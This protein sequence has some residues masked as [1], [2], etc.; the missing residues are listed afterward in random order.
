M[1]F[2]LKS[3]EKYNNMDLLSLYDFIIEL[4]AEKEFDNVLRLIHDT[5]F[6]HS[7]M[8]QLLEK[9]FVELNFSSW[10]HLSVQEKTFLRLQLF[11][12]PELL[13]TLSN[14]QN[15]FDFIISTSPFGNRDNLKITIDHD[16]LM[17]NTLFF[18]FLYQQHIHFFSLSIKNQTT[19]NKKM[20]DIIHQ[21]YIVYFESVKINQWTNLNPSYKNELGNIG[22]FH[23]LEQIHYPFFHKYVQQHI[24]AIH[25]INF[26]SIYPHIYMHN[27]YTVLFRGPKSDVECSLLYPERGEQEKHIKLFSFLKKLR[28][29]IQYN[30]N[31]VD[32]DLKIYIQDESLNILACHKIMDTY[33]A[34]ILNDQ[35]NNFFWERIDILISILN[36]LHNKDLTYDIFSGYAKNQKHLKTLFFKEC[37]LNHFFKHFSKNK[38][39]QEGIFLSNGF[40]IIPED[41]EEKELIEFREEMMSHSIYMQKLQLSK[42]V[43]TTMQE[44]S[45]VLP[46]KKKPSRL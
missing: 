38:I 14:K 5:D 28:A 2:L 24:K 41:V 13:D 1:T 9:N 12:F 29:I 6:P 43:S 3:K 7:E 35:K 27:L 23:T 22:I 16:I 18:E 30:K 4:C 37:V 8:N 46:S 32:H 17:K 34:S 39:L 42:I 20:F 26:L 33:Y 15:I 25:L 10:K 19:H 45:P 31:Y 36:K 44:N 11:H 40:D 21:Q